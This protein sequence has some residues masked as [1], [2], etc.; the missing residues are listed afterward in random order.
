MELG[1]RECRNLLE[2]SA[3]TLKDLSISIGLS[4]GES[5]P[6]LEF[7]SLEVLELYEESA[8]F[9]A[10]MKVNSNL[11]LYAEVLPSNLPSI[12]EVWVFYL[13]AGWRG[14]SMSCP[15][16]KVLTFE[17]EEQLD[18]P[19]LE[20]LLVT[21]RENVERGLE[22]EAVK[23]EPLRKLVIP[24]RMFTSKMLEKL[25]VLVDEVVDYDAE[26]SG[27]EVRI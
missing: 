25:R 14:L 24:S 9:P 10:W 4:T 15:L 1:H 26:P 16:L 23:M 18:L 17:G 19:N 3:R 2:A 12:S 21:R 5:V 13:T 22:I 27:W 6:P 8:V 20:S 11:K 7:P